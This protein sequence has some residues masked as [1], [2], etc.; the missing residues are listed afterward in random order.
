MTSN[1]AT[2]STADLGAVDELMKRNSGTVGF[3]P[4]EAL[5][6]YLDKGLVLGVFAGDGRLIAYLLYAA[7]RD[8]FRITQLCVA[9]DFR[10]QGLARHLL[11]ALR[12]SAST[13][14]LVTLSCRNDFPAHNMWPKLGFIPIVEK[15]GRSRE[16]YPLTLWRLI[17]APDDQL[18]LFRANASESVLDVV[19]DAQVFFDFD[20]PESDANRPSKVLISDFFADSVN[21][22]YTDEL[23]SEINRNPNPEER[24][25][26]RRRATDFWEVR[27]DPVS[28][29]FLAE[30][31]RQV[32]PSGTDSQQ[33]DINHLAKAASSD[34]GFFVTRDRRILNRADEIANLVGLHVLSPTELV[35]RLNE[36]SETHVY[37][38]DRVS[39]L[40][41]QWRRFSSEEFSNFPFDRFLNQGEALGRLRDRVSSLLAESELHDVEVL[42]L[43]D[44]PVALRGLAYGTNRALTITLGRIRASSDGALFGRFLISDAVYRAAKMGLE[45]INLDMS[46]IPTDPILGLSDMGFRRH[47]NQF[48]RFC[49]TRFLGREGTLEKMGELCPEVVDSFRNDSLSELERSCS[50][51]SM[52][53]EQNFFLIPI[54]EGYAINLIDRERAAQDLF[55]GNPEVLLRWENVYY[56][57]ATHHNMLNV[58]ARIL[59]YISGNRGEIAYISRLDEVV[60]DTPKELFRRFRRIGTLEWADLYEMCGRNID[61]NLMALKF[62]HTFPLDRS[63]PLNE[64]WEVFDEDGVGRSVQ[65]PTRLPESTFRKLFE[66]GYPEEQ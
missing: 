36:L 18:E 65:G 35:I 40:N 30:S 57:A 48:V 14:K 41:L 22:W 8:R 19:L 23:L 7:N 63:V 15:P 28:V 21:L 64:I 9:E 26:A 20:E 1:I 3:L 62:S 5:R 13:Q 54:R 29:E 27:H 59:W 4:L 45:M 31:L 60:I 42:W 38:P 50:P 25:A 11:D 66:R 6:D 44:E 46:S 32:L 55:G 49:F 39:G 47:G 37:E 33:S 61:T 10:G 34:V 43:G 56:R 51:L 12:D 2:L 24:G 52:S 16:G 17:L 58:P 53:S